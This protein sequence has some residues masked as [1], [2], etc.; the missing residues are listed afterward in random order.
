[1]VMMQPLRF[2]VRGQA[3]GADAH[4]FAPRSRFIAE[5]DLDAFDLVGAP[6]PA[7]AHTGTSTEPVPIRVDLKAGMRDMWR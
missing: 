5:T 6:T 4:V 7:D 1:L 3:R 2:F